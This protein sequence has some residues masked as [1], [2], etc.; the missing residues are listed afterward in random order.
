MEKLPYESHE[1]ADIA[2]NHVLSCLRETGITD[3]SEKHNWIESVCD[4]ARHRLGK[5][6]TTKA[7]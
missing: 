3:Y 6:G 7:V 1:W 4:K 2:T 5:N